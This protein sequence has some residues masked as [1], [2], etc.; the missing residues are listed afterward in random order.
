MTMMLASSQGYHPLIKDG[1]VVFELFI[2]FSTQQSVPVV[3]GHGPATWLG[4]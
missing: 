1:E 2:D 3:A 4:G